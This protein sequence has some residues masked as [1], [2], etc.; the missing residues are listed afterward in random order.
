MWILKV[1]GHGDR[2][3]I[4]TLRQ[5]HPRMNG[6]A[7]RAPLKLDPARFSSRRRPRTEAIIAEELLKLSVAFIEYEDGELRV[8][9]RQGECLIEAADPIRAVGGTEKW[10]AKHH[11]SLGIA[12]KSR[13]AAANVI[14]LARAGYEKCHKAQVWAAANPELL[15][16]N[17]LSGLDYFVI[18]LRRY[19]NRPHLPAGP[20]TKRPSKPDREKISLAKLDVYQNWIHRLLIDLAKACAAG[21]NP[22][23]LNA[24]RF[25]MEHQTP[26]NATIDTSNVVSI[27]EGR[28]ADA[29]HPSERTTKRQVGKHKR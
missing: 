5:R 27:A 8:H 19:R 23:V 28:S 13:T 4:A 20:V 7:V 21:W 22:R 1:T 12:G 17:R 16:T 10:L 2:S 25:E 29:A 6:N 26:S 18:A 15:R 11:I 9:I 14:F 24:I 3:M